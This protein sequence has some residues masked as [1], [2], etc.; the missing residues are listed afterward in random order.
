MVPAASSPEG[1]V[2]GHRQGP[3]NEE[4]RKQYEVSPPPRPLPP[5]PSPHTL[6]SD[7]VSLEDMLQSAFNTSS[8]PLTQELLVSKGVLQRLPGRMCSLLVK[9]SWGGCPR[10]PQCC[11]GHWGLGGGG[12]ASLPVQRFSDSVRSDILI[13]PLNSLPR[14]SKVGARRLFLACRYAYLAY[15]EFK[16]CSGGCYGLNCISSKP[17]VEVLTPAAHTSECDLIWQCCCRCN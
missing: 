16:N 6:E 7:S 10:P 13:R 11:R 15:A 9:Y 8:L 14:V 5:P 12:M 4:P 1:G 2:R 3:H 17:Y